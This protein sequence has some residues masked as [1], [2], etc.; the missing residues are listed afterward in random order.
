MLRDGREVALRP[1]TFA[2]LRYLVENAGRLVSK[3]ELFA[4]VWPNV[5]TTDDVL[6]QS[7]SEM[8]RALEED[9]PDLVRTVPR[10]GYRFESPVSPVAEPQRPIAIPN[11]KRVHFASAP[12]GRIV[13]L[14]LP[15]LA[16]ALVAGLATLAV[17]KNVVPIATGGGPAIAVLPFTQQAEDLSRDYFADGLTQD[18]IN[19]LGRFSGLTVMSWNAVFPFKERPAKPK[20]IGSNLGVGYLLEG[21]VNEVG[22]RVRVT[23]EL[24]DASKGKV[25]WSADFD[26]AM[27][28]VF[29]VRDNISNQVVRALAVRVTQIEQRRVFAKPTE[30][31]EA[32]DYLLRARP[33][34][35]RPTRE[36]NA[37]ART[38]LKRAIEV[39]PN[40]ADAYA[41]LGETYYT[42]A[43]M[44]WAESPGEAVNRAEE[45]ARKAL[46]IDSR[47]VRAHVVLG[48]IDILHQEYE[49][50]GVEIDDALAT[51][52]NDS[53]GLAGRGNI[54]LW[55]G[56][57]DAAIATL[58][59][60]QHID[61]DLRAMDRFALSLSYYLRRRYDAAINTAELTLRETSGADFSRVVLA[62][63][64]AQQG[65]TG[66]VAPIVEKIRSVDPTF[67]A[68]EFGTKFVN[69]VDLEQLR[70]GL[71][72]AGLYPTQEPM[73]NH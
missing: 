68:R 21:S 72:K 12:A 53:Q 55:L 1:K 8:R 70:D 71:R 16:V 11:T 58:E 30:N 46:R 54:L 35:L 4:A 38:L 29:A 69:A 7:I 6:V 61:P 2:V 67:D 19:E 56:Q 37:E 32:Y 33:A 27:A 65:R 64:Y 13:L 59:Q 22:R 42:S 24:V 49:Q 25:L 23:T 5:T 51:N 10:R 40:Y 14:F 20:E 73:V 39:D 9:G 3:D 15:I 66:E 44:G 31:L 43:S 62:A 34:L 47:V 28:D 18:I 57:T 41:A 52:P 36:N 50:A 63:A 26:A 45:L 60:A 17:K 48:R